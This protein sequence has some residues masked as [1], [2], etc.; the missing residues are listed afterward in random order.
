MPVLGKRNT[1]AGVILS[2]GEL[3]PDLLPSQILNVDVGAESYVVGEIPAVVVGVFVDYDVIGI[4]KP[5]IA[6]GEIKSR[7]GEVETA[8]P[9]TAGATT[10]DAPDVAAAEAAGEVA[11][12]PGV[13]EVEAGLVSAVVVPYPPAVVVDVRGFGVTFIV[14]IGGL[15]RSFVRHAM[16]GRGTMMRNV[17]A[18]YCMAA[19]FVATMLRE[20]R[21][22]K[23]QQD[24]KNLWD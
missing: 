13:I 7:D 9:E 5:V 15:G 3:L 21:E 10:P 18:T 12:L 1:G 14:A 23:G 6:E 8:K 19:A 22:R 2:A 20:G 16:R 24:S 17:T 4:P 11:V